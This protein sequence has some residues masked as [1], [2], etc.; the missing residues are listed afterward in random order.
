MQ[1]VLDGFLSSDIGRIS[2]LVVTAAFPEVIIVKKV[3]VPVA[4]AFIKK[5]SHEILKF[6]NMFGGTNSGLRE[7]HSNSWICG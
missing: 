3:A 1:K 2:S 7:I 6:M 5:V 4:R